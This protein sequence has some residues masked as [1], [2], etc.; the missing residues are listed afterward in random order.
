MCLLR[1]PPFASV[2][3]DKVGVFKVVNNDYH[4]LGLSLV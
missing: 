3:A 1:L 4:V 2:Q